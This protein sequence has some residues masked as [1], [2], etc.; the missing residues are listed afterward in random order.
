MTAMLGDRIAALRSAGQAIAIGHEAGG[1]IA[2]L[3]SVG[4]AIAIGHGAGGLMAID[5]SVDSPVG[6]A[7]VPR[8]LESS[9][10]VRCNSTRTKTESSIGGSC[11]NW[12]RVW[13]VA[14]T[15]PEILKS[16]IRQIL[17]FKRDQSTTGCRNTLTDRP[18]WRV[19]G[20]AATAD[21]KRTHVEVT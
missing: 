5:V 1:R 9:W 21:K 11:R 6:S 15:R 3:Q 7:A 17:L 4:Q 16:S 14:A 13:D 20:A 18:P 2:A 10:T 8:I 12:Q 19:T